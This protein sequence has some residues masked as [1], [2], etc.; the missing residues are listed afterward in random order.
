[1]FRTQAHEINRPCGRKLKK[2]PLNKRKEQQNAFE[3]KKKN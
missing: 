3:W 1:M 2:I